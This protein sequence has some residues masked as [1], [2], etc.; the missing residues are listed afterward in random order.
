[1]T[2]KLTDLSVF[3]QHL[4]LA[5]MVE[6]YIKAAVPLRQSGVVLSGAEL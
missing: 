5:Q 4:N 2:V 1:M 3:S 6:T